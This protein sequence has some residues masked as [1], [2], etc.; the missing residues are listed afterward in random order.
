VTTSG[1]RAT[2]VQDLEALPASLRC[3]GMIVAPIGGMSRPHGTVGVVPPW[4]RRGPAGYVDV[5]SNCHV[6]ELL[7][8]VDDGRP[9]LPVYLADGLK[10]V[11]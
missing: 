8:P 2:F 7:E 10:A 9:H 4:A 11:T 1:E 6:V 3:V 5:P